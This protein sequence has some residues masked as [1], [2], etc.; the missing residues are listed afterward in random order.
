MKKKDKNF[1]IFLLYS[2]IGT[3]AFLINISIFT[4]LSW[5]GLNIYISNGVAFYTGL[6]F[7]Y[8]ANSKITF[9]KE[10]L[11]NKITIKRWLFYCLICTIGWS[12][13]FLILNILIYFNKPAD[14]NFS[15][16]LIKQHTVKI[17]YNT[18]SG[19][20]GGIFNY[21]VVKNFIFKK[22]IKNQEEVDK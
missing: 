22:K 10:H 16:I 6:T 19:A 2:L 9:K 20:I 3:L 4:F 1:F 13:N 15:N 8:L 12:V 18:I 7:S 21:I 17:I 11:E 14:I 5:L